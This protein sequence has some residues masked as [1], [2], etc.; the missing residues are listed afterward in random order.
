MGAPTVLQLLE[1][2]QTV[3]VLS[4]G[5]PAGSEQVHGTGGQRGVTL[6]ADVPTIVCDRDSEGPKLQNIITTGGFD[7]VVDFYAMVPRHVEDVVKAHAVRGL[8]HYVFVSTNMVYPG[9]PGNFDISDLEPRPVKEEAAVLE[10]AGASPDDYGGRKL[11][12]EA[13]LLLQE[14]RQKLPWTVIRPPSVCVS[15]RGSLADDND[16][17]RACVWGGDGCAC[18]C[19]SVRIALGRC[20][21]GHMPWALGVWCVF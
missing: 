4:R 17:T 20:R 10:S 6:P 12:C 3:T 1:A 11:K 8:A 7:A 5:N 21:R 2:G 16:H 9:G 19:L 18:S 15:K 13:V 14:H